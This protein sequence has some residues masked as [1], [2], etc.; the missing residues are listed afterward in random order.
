MYFHYICFIFS[1]IINLSLYTNIVHTLP[2]MK[3]NIQSYWL[4]STLAL[5]ARLNSIAFMGKSEDLYNRIVPINDY[6]NTEFEELYIKEILD[7]SKSDTV[8]TN[9]ILLYSKSNDTVDSMIKSD[10]FDL[11]VSLSAV[12]S[13][14][15]ETSKCLF[16]FLFCILI[17]IIRYIIDYNLIIFSKLCI[18][19]IHNTK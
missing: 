16:F 15:N 2:M 12:N 8:L 10:V 13:I 11:I 19:I 14:I 7:F 3:I 6:I 9:N 18:N 5:K 17:N 4:S 1:V